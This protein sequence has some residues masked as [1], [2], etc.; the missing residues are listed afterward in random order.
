MDFKDVAKIAIDMAPAIGGALAIPTG[1]ASVA[2]GA[3]IKALGSVFGLGESAKP[4]EIAKAI[5]GDPEAAFK[6]KVAEQNFIL[7]MRKADNEELKAILSDVQGARTRQVES[8]KVTG[9]RDLN[10]YVLAWVIVLGFFSLI[11]VLLYVPLPEDSTGVVFML[12]GSLSAGFGAVI[13]YFFGSS[14]G[15]EVKTTLLA[16]TSPIK[17]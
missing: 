7:E 15:S 17:E 5:Q 14:W 2:V 3:A 6:L 13:Q 12:F 4:E 11:A 8:E 16:K 1:G 10:I 9:K